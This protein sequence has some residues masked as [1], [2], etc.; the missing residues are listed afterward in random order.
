LLP[1]DPRASY[2]AH[3]DEIDQAVSTV[4]G[5]GWYILGQEVASFENEFAQYL[6]A[7]HVLGVGSG[8]DALHLAM[9]V[10][11]SGAGD[12]VVTV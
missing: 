10:L 6:G 12:V 8:T 11:G 7:E 3:K 9:R 5:R 1:A 4:L 2:L